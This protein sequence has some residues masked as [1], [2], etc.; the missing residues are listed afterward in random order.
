MTNIW[1]P[2]QQQAID[3]RGRSI[4]VSAAA[5]S[6]K[7]SVL[8][9]RL[10]QILISTTDPVPADR[11]VVVTFTND[12][13][14][15]MKRRLTVALSEMQEKDPE[16][17]WLS[18]QQSLLQT[19]HISTI[20]S[21]C[22]DLIRENIHL[23]DI[24]PGFRILDETGEQV[25][26]VQTLQRIL[27]QFC[28][29]YPE[30]TTLLMDTF[31]TR[32]EKQLEDVIL[33]FYDFL[34]SIPFWRQWL[35]RQ[36]SYYIVEN[37]ITDTNWCESYFILLHQKL[38]GL[39]PHVSQA[40]NLAEEWEF[41]K[42][43]ALLARERENFILLAESCLD[44]TL[45]WDERIQA[46]RQIK[47]DT[48]RFP[49]I[50]KGAPE[51]EVK[52]RIQA[53]RKLYK[54]QFGKIQ[55]ICFLES[56][57][58]D[59][60]EWHQKIITALTHLLFLMDDEL[61]K[62]KKDKNTISFADAEQM[63]VKLLAELKPD[64]HVEATELA[65]ELAQY[66][67]IIMIDEY[68]DVNPLQ[69]LIFK[70]LSKGGTE[71][72]N[73]ENLFVVGDVKQS[74][75]RFRQAAPEIFIQ[76]LQSARPCAAQ[77][78]DSSSNQYILLN[79]N[80]RSSSAVV[81]FVNSFFRR[82]MSVPVGEIDYT[83]QEELIQGAVYNVETPR[84]V[85]FLMMSTEEAKDLEGQNYMTDEETESAM[86]EDEEELSTEGVVQEARIVAA[87][88]HQMLKEQHSVY[89][90]GKLRPC[91]SKDFC[92][93][94]RNRRSGTLFAREMEK[95]GIK[96]HVDEVEGYL[97]SR[98]ISVLLN[99]LQVIDNPLW[100]IA[101]VSVL[102]SPMFMLTA[103]DVAEIRLFC[104]KGNFYRAICIALEKPFFQLTESEGIVDLEAL[105]SREEKI[106]KSWYLK[107]SAFDQVL[108]ELRYCAA[109]Y[110]LEELIRTIYD[111]TD[112][113]SVVQ[114]Y[115]DGEQKKANLRLLLNYA[116]SY[117]EDQ[118]G[119][120]S[121]FVR[122]MRELSRL[123]GDL[124]RAGIV[125]QA[126]DAVSVKTIHKSKGLEFPFVFLCQTS[127]SFSRQ[128]ANK[129]VQLHMQR[130]IG[131]RIRRRKELK[132]YESLPYY[133][134]RELN[135]AAL[136][137]EEMRLLY[138]ALTR[139]K[140]KIFLTA[141]FSD[142]TQK[143]LQKCLPVLEAEGLTA[144]LIS[145]ASSMNDW[146]TM[147]LLCHQA[148]GYLRNVLGSS[149]QPFIR[150]AD[151]IVT[152]V[153]EIAVLPAE[154]MSER[155]VQPDLQL[156]EEIDRKV[157]FSYLDTL[158]KI[159]AKLTVSEIVKS[160]EQ[161]N[162]VYEIRLSKPRFLL[163]EGRFS[164]V[165]RGLAT[166]AF[167]Q[168]ADYS[169]AAKDIISERDRLVMMGFLSKKEGSAI[170]IKKLQRFFSS[171]LYQRMSQSR[172][173][174]RERKFL[175][176]IDDLNLT[177]ELGEKY[178][179]TD[180]M[181]Q[182][183]ADCLFEEHDGFVL[184]DYKTDIGVTEEKLRYLYGRQLEL[185]QYSLNLLYEKGIKEAGIYSFYLGEYFRFTSV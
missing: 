94:L 44:V 21:F 4:I 9:E 131:V 126:E 144:E 173:I 12:A 184:V 149:L 174:L 138:V 135:M 5:G 115:R 43:P 103:E 161:E 178:Q 60:L 15:E 2:E 142:K 29:L 17:A 85:E 105:P 47:F 108:E 52:S 168:Y 66:Y 90:K 46:I 176:K 84:H 165:Q 163:I 88:I 164:G 77:Q 122:Y 120:L 20:H 13:A 93:L 73:G 72:K 24:A 181:L 119:G 35:S 26:L 145:S 18:M 41:P 117:E 182:G 104:P 141:D 54:D 69:D 109:G 172:Q 59:D 28:D 53:I 128:D 92:V 180:G 39:I 140:E 185:Y 89:E 19:A 107:L 42:I 65:L 153:K 11:I 50:E 183:I 139:A 177:D 86:Q 25:L 87:K 167:L 158:T 160:E 96:A 101:L 175:M 10:L 75:Y 124:K 113:L 154:S 22:F 34:M 7:T 1:T 23:L 151:I 127:V 58:V 74:I 8:V 132:R 159:P 30:E 114:V 38:L 130:G 143:K 146:L 179:K 121:G 51:D 79:R 100:E 57:V 36:V 169:L 166:H 118:K 152:D 70:F 62:R 106:Q 6:G 67:A 137:S 136:K 37:S 80:F 16:N 71:E 156:V 95:M 155:I 63:T 61:Q 3:V 97:R 123:G 78:K 110:S 99:L 170:E 31:C 33:Q 32:N 157:S 147:Y 102:M 49:K 82:M 171:S 83:E 45:T 148:G 112:F 27:E 14:A 116:R 98:E 76:T 134:I 150:D 133:V 64:G 162:P 81:D 68:Q 111:S 40:L 48:M 56:E 55:K 125:S 91:S 129:P